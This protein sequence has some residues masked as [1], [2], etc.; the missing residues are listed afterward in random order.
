[1]IRKAAVLIFLTLPL[2]AC[3]TEEQKEAKNRAALAKIEAEDDAYCQSYG[4]AKGSPDY[5]S[6][7]NNQTQ[8]RAASATAAAANNAAMSRALVTQGTTMM[9]QGFGGH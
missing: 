6:C 2:C 5:V 8:V 3:V 4:V 1:M 7:R 9:N